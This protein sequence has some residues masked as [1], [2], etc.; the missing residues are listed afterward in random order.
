MGFI[1]SVDKS[2]PPYIRI[3]FEGK[4]F[5]SDDIRQLVSLVKS[6]LQKMSF[7]FKNPYASTPVN[8]YYMINGVNYFQDD[9]DCTQIELVVNSFDDADKTEYAEN[10][11]YGD[12]I[13]YLMKYERNGICTYS[14]SQIFWEEI[15]Q[16]NRRHASLE[17]RPEPDKVL[18]ILCLALGLGTEEYALLQKLRR[19]EFGDRT[20]RARLPFISSG[21]NEEQKIYD[22]LK[23][24]HWRKLETRRQILKLDMREEEL[25]SDM[26]L[27]PRKLLFKANVD[28]LLSNQPNV[29]YNPI[30]GLSQEEVYDILRI[31]GITSNLLDRFYNTAN[32]E[33]YRSLKRQH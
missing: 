1:E 21:G 3:P 25:Q 27:L 29:I 30:I 16:L 9:P 18:L 20:V 31:D 7:V 22:M 8:H 6:H 12:Y 32:S 33:G 11:G 28:L 23:E 19:K 26:L 10:H 15:V 13:K 17:S 5:N 2:K 14:R 24:S 4:G